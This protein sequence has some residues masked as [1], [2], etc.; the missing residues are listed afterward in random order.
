MSLEAMLPLV[1][2]TPEINRTDSV[3]SIF[4]DNTQ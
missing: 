2:E 3:Y 4:S 1:R